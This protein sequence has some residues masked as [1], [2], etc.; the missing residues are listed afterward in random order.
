MNMI[1]NSLFSRKR[2]ET[3]LRRKRGAV[4]CQRGG[5]AVGK[6]SDVITCIS[7]I[8][9]M[10]TWLYWWSWFPQK[11]IE[12]NSLTTY[13]LSLWFSFQG[14]C[15][16]HVEW[17]VIAFF[18]RFES[19]WDWS[20]LT[21]YWREGVVRLWVVVTENIGRRRLLS[22]C[23]DPRIF[24][25]ITISS[26]IISQMIWRVFATGGVWLWVNK[27]LWHLSVDHREVEAWSDVRS[28]EGETQCR[29]L[30]KNWRK[31]WLILLQAIVS[32]ALCVKR[33]IYRYSWW[34][35]WFLMFWKMG[36][37]AYGMH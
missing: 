34:W 35:Q 16:H 10:R 25:D 26:C 37:F 20:V 6:D 8:V 13:L 14:C 5:C 9:T 7:V 27:S 2:K 22:I 18:G 3:Q 21:N 24:V 28:S 31:K 36:K 15:C 17:V 23:S 11:E 4:T 29:L 1:V 12:E 33:N 19:S 32:A 30:T